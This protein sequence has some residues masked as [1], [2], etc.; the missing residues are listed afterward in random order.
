MKEKKRVYC[1]GDVSE[2]GGGGGPQMEIKNQTNRALLLQTKEACKT[3]SAIINKWNEKK[4]KPFRDT[5]RGELDRTRVRQNTGPYVEVQ[6]YH[7]SLEE[8]PL[9]ADWVTSNKTHEKMG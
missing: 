1:E 8:N 7:S 5:L 9:S 3:V 4:K 2:K 6:R